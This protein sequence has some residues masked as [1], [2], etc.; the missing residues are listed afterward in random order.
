MRFVEVVDGRPPNF[1]AI[2]AV[3]PEAAK[4]GVIFAYGGRI[5]APGRKAVTP[6]LQAHEQTHLERQ[7]DA[8]ERWWDRYLAETQFRL[9][10]E[11]IAHAREYQAYCRR[12]A[13]PGKRALMLEHIA[14]KL[15]SPLYGEIITLEDARRAIRMPL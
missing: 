15:S 4:P 9:E 6:A 10:E 11:L 3:F 12:H 7:G 1:E 8:P 5:Y 14:G 13:E 2:F